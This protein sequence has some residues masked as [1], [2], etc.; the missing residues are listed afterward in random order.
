MKSAD[1][2]SALSKVVDRV[3]TVSLCANSPFNAGIGRGVVVTIM[4]GRVPSRRPSCNVSSVS[5]GYAQ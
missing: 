3:V 4:R 1:K 5:S 2:F